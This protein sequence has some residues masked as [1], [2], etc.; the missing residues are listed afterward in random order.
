MAGT[1]LF[2]LLAP[3]GWR[4]LL[5]VGGTAESGFLSMRT[6]LKPLRNLRQLDAIKSQFLFF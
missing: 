4:T 5:G 1:L 6:G 3:S 2:K